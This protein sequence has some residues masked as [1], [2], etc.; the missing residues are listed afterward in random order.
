MR[1]SRIKP[2]ISIRLFVYFYLGAFVIGSVAGNQIWKIGEFRDYVSVY[3]VLEHY[4]TQK[5]NLKQYAVFLLREKGIFAAGC[6]IAGM[7]GAGE[8]FAAVI[9]LW[10]GFLAGGLSTLFLL[11]SGMK[12]FL[13]CMTGV[14]SQL[15]FYIPA[16]ILF[17]LIMGRQSRGMPRYAEVSAKEM[18]WTILLILIFLFVMGI[19]II[20][21][22]YVNSKL[23]MNLF[24]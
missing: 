20:A 6:I 3:G 19:G 4:E 16:A 8:I 9:S 5:T 10:L 18:R 24:F 23:W 17:L 7:A 15:L 11:Q 21:E 2:D 13:F 1:W 22:T 14:I 12:G